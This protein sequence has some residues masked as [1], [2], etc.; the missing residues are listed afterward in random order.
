MTELLEIFDGRTVAI[1]GNGEEAQ[2]CSAEIDACDIVLR[3]NH[4]YNYDSGRVGKKVDVIIQTF[5]TPWVKAENK[6]A[7]VIKAQ[8]PKIFCG[9]KPEQFHPAEVASFLGGDICV[10]DWTSELRPWMKY[11]TG[12]AFLCWLASRPR[13]AKFKVFGFPRGAAADRYFSGDAINYAKIKDEELAA[14]A[15]A[16]AIIESQ[17]V[18]TPRTESKPIILIPVKA[19]S[20]GAPGKNDVLLPHCVEKLLP[21]G[22]EIHL[23]GDA[24]DLMERT[25]ARFAGVVGASPIRVFVTPPPTGEVTDDLRLWRDYTGYHGEIIHIQCTS[26]GLKLEW[27]DQCLEAR[28]HAPISATCCRVNFKVN[29]MYAEANGAWCQLVPNFGPPSVPRQKLPQVVHL[30]GAVFCFHSDALDRK[31]FYQAGTLRPVIV[32]ERDSLDVDTA[33][34]LAK[35]VAQL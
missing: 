21:L 4:F 31:S 1:V 16:I 35:A 29:G 17:T 18:K 33:E 8:Q 34:D 15:R 3:F 32:E 6:H 26:P 13:N 25:A 19:H 12:G 2:D 14:Q 9:K 24:K 7:D 27:I 5:T 10:S 22:Y 11:T 23:V 20:T 28:R 30:N